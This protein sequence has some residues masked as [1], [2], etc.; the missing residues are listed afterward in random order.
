MYT[1]RSGLVLG[2]HGCDKSIVENIIFGKSKL[3]KSRRK[4]N[5]LGTGIYFWEN[6]PIRAIDYAKEL[7]NSPLIPNRPT[8]KTPAVI[9]AVISLG[10]CLDLLNYNDLKLVKLAY[11]IL[12][13]SYNS[14]KRK[15]PRNKTPL[16]SKD[17][18]IR[19][20]DCRVINALH[21]IQKNRGESPF[22]SVRAPFW[23]GTDLYENAGFKEKNHI[24]I[25]ILNPN[26]IKGYFLPRGQNKIY[27]K[28]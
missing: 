2:F 10:H 9:G 7:K 27:S 12:C 15:L 18:L 13:I 8:I 25:C 24:Q 5:W 14:V 28:V 19:E 4:Y 3:R 26:C 23:E 20:L 11:E 17:K 22:D 16:G 21:T 1:V 6:D